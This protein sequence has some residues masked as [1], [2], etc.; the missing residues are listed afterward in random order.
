MSKTSQLR[1]GDKFKNLYFQE[2]GSCAEDRR[3]KER[4]NDQV[5]LA[6]LRLRRALQIVPPDPRNLEQ[7]ADDALHYIEAVRNADRRI[8]LAVIG[9]SRVA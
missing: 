9:V 4:L 6:R 3:E 5:R 2:V 7:L 8:G 1:G